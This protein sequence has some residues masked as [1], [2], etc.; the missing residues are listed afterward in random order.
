LKPLTTTAAEAM[1]QA[2]KDL[3]EKKI[4]AKDAQAIAQLGIGVVQAAN[5]E[6]AFIRA[7]KSLPLDGGFGDNVRFL[8]PPK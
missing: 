6:I 7:T 1:I 8:E 4:D 2:M 5:A 3:S